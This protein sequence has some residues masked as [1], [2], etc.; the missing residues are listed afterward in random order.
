MLQISPLLQAQRNYGEKKIPNFFAVLVCGRVACWEGKRIG[1]KSR[2]HAYKVQF[3]AHTRSSAIRWWWW[4]HRE[5]KKFFFFFWLSH[6]M[7]I[8]DR[9]YHTFPKVQCPLTDFF[10]TQRWESI[11]VIIRV[12]PKQKIRKIKKN[13]FCFLIFPCWHL[14]RWFAEQW[15]KLVVKPNHVVTFFCKCQ[16]IL[17]P[18][19]FYGIVCTIMAKPPPSAQRV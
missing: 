4:C 6:F 2:L 17:P 10:A 5:L 12:V 16:K 19:L 18:K 1:I 11:W 3:A 8:L 9:E 15:K 14:I 7:P 13:S